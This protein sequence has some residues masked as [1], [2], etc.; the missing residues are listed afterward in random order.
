MFLASVTRERVRTSTDSAATVWPVTSALSVTSRSTERLT[1]NGVGGASGASEGAGPQAARPRQSPRCVLPPVA[2]SPSSHR[3][4]IAPLVGRHCIGYE[5]QRRSRAIDVVPHG[6][7]TAHPDRP[8]ELAVHLDGKP[9]SRSRISQAL[10]SGNI[11]VPERIRACRNTHP[12]QSMCL[13]AATCAPMMN[14]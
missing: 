5:R 4:A 10:N 14:R 3:V 1:V 9:P 6:G 13:A 12:T 11:R 8:D 2:C 7:S